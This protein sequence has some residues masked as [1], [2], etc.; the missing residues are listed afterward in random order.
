G[1]SLNGIQGDLIVNGG[2]GSNTLNANDSSSAGGQ[3]YTL[4]ATQLTGTDF[5]A[6][7][8]YASLHALTVTGSGSEMLTLVAPAPLALVTFPGGSGSNTLV[9]ANVANTWT[10]SG[11]YTG[12][13]GNVTFDN[14]QSL[15]GGNSSDTFKFISQSAGE[16][17]INGGGGTNKLDYSALGSSF[18][19]TVFLTSNTTGS[20][21]QMDTPFRN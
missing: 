13:V 11:A 19:M 9:G 12:K 18:S 10:L 17:S 5:F 6:N 16:H 1:N 14:F 2:G 4:S 21:P 7:I 15:V 3:S 8:T 20:A